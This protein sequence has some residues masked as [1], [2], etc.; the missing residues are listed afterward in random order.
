MSYCPIC[1]KKLK[2]DSYGI[3]GSCKIPLE[4]LVICPE[5]RGDGVIDSGGVM[6]W[7]EHIN[8]GCELCKGVGKAD[9]ESIKKAGWTIGR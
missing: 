4:R 5:C 8:I 9:I 3:A 2:L 6:P 7:G 1:N